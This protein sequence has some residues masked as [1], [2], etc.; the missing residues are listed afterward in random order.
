MFE[1][2]IEDRVGLILRRRDQLLER[3]TAVGIDGITN[4]LSIVDQNAQKVEI[5]GDV[6]TD[7]IYDCEKE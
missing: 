6:Q 5:H 2:S 1:V 3:M 7:Q 4:D